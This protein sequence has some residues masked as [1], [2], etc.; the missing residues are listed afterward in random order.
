MIIDGSSRSY[1]VIRHLGSQ[2]WLLMVL[3]DRIL[4]SVIWGHRNDHRWFFMIVFCHPPSGVTAMIIDGSSRSY[5]VI[6]HLGSPQWSSMVLHDRILS[7]VIWGHSNDHWWFFTIVFCQP[8]S[9]VTAMIIDGS[10]RSY[11]V[12][13][14]LGSQQWL[15]M[16][17]HD[18][19]L[20]SVIWGHR[21]DHRWFFT[22]VFCHPSSGVTAMIIDGSS[23]SYSVIRHLGSPQWSSM[24][25]HDRILSSVI[26]GHHNDHW[27]FFT[28][29]FCHPSSGVTAMIID[30]SSRSY[31]VI[32]HLGS[33]QW[34][35]MVLHDR[36]LSSVIWGH[37]NDHRWFF[38]IVFCHPSSGVTAMI[39]DGSSRSYSVIRHLGSPQWSL[40]V[41]HDRILSSVIWGHRNDHWWFF[42]IV[43]CHP[44][45]GVTAMI[46]DGSSRSYSVSRHLGSPQ[47]SLMVLHDRIL[48]SAIWGQRND[49][50]WFFTIVFCQPPSGVTAMIIDGSS[51]S[52][53]V[54]RHLGSPQWSLMV[55]HDRILSSVIWGHRNDH[56]WFFTIVF[57]HPSSGVTAM[58]ID[59]SSRSYS[60]TRHLGSPQ[61]SSMVLHDR[62]LSSVIWGH[63]NDYWWFFTIVFCH[64]SSGVTA[65]I[66]DGSSR[67]YSVI[68]HLGSPQ[69]SLMV[70]HDRILSPVIWGHRNDHWWFFTIVFCHPSSGV[71]TMIIDGSSRSY[72]V[73]R[74]LGSPQWS[75][76]VLHDRILSSVIWGHHN[77]HWWFFTIV[78][79]H[80]SSGVTAMIIDGSSRSYS[81]IRHLGSPQWSLMVLHD[82]ILSSVIW[83]HRNDHRWFFTIVFCHPS[84]GVTAMI[85]DGSSRS[86]SVIRH[87]GSPQWSSMVLH[88][89]ILS[90]VI[91]GHRNDH[92]WFFTIVFCHPSSGVTAMII[93]GSSR[94]YSVIRHLGS[95]Q[96]SSMVLHDRI[97]SAVI[98]GHSN[99]YWWF[100][101]I[102]FCQ[103]SSGVTAM[104]IDGSSRSYSVIR[105]LG[106]PQ[107]SSMVLHDRILSSVIWGHHNDHWWFFTIIFCHP[108]SG[109]T[110]M[111]IDGS[112]RSYSVIRHLGS[113]QW[114]LMVLHDR[115][116]SSVIWG[117]RNDHWWFFTIV[118]C[119]P[120]S[121]VTA[122]IIDGSS[123]SYSV[124]RHLGSPQWSSMVLHD[125]ILSSVIWGHHNDHWWFFTI[126]FCHPSSGVTTMI[127]DGS[128]RSYSV[129]RHLGS[130]QWLLMVLHDRILSSAIF[131]SSATIFMFTESIHI[132]L[133]LP[134]FLGR[135]MSIICLQACSSGR[136][137]LRCKNHF[138]RVYVILLDIFATPIDP[139]M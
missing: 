56:R 117:H 111:I 126:V 94:S 95:P 86:Y 22:I 73:I 123:R 106:S 93:D 21:N 46:I 115:I 48:S 71:T 120:S 5:S 43:F 12:I 90:S 62:I 7:S 6:R 138:N 58:I 114:S 125:R 67:S 40:M 113:P 26:W 72:S 109:V 8:P 53:S 89:R 136:F 128:S 66:I 63:S 52:Y 13:R 30:G 17:L 80:P 37:R 124:T 61:W 16:V 79:C 64:P 102:V 39:I 1:S 35:L 68:R 36:I 119:H 42:T 50:W 44:S 9:G 103:P 14:H 76:M 108:S 139:R 127:I 75:S 45:S 97:L 134:L 29:V 84:S 49:H 121:G 20:S 98:W 96:W 118:F 41:L 59:G 34:L 135:S 74:H 104:I 38:T 28:I 65:M 2:Q 70:L 105:H 55:L 33:Q 92:W 11:S 82:R 3:H 137:K 116:L 60:V 101:T 83:G 77:D 129:I 85:I 87:L 15:L 57:C 24:V 47:W 132:V 51:R 27:W 10:S 54:I 69:W 133:G 99:D 31:S 19:I 131:L 130:Q 112:S 18:R 110:A 122:M 88:D 23:R 78:F 25:L 91:W 81:V 4:S 32:R 100:F 107:W